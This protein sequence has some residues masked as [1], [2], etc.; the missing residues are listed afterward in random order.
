[1]KYDFYYEPRS[2]FDI[3]NRTIPYV[4][5]STMKKKPKSHCSSTIS[6]TTSSSSGELNQM[7]TQKAL[8]KAEKIIKR[9]ANEYFQIFGHTASLNE[10]WESNKS[11]NAAA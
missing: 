4:N 6:P 11:Q 5:Q 8:A 7:A 10:L 1:M 3:P 9:E 2:E